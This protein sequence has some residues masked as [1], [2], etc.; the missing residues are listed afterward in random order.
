MNKKILSQQTLVDYLNT[1]LD[2]EKFID[3]D[4]S[5]NGLQIYG[6]KNNIKNIICSVDLSVELI[7]EAIKL[8][9]DM[10]IV[11][12]GIS[13]DGGIKYIDENNYKKISKLI[14]NNIS[15]YAIHLPLD[16][17]RKLGNNISI[18][19][20]IVTSSYI[21][22]IDNISSNI[23]N[24]KTLKDIGVISTIRPTHIDVLSKQ[25]DNNLNK[26]IEENSYKTI[27]ITQ[28]QKNNISIYDNSNSKKINRIYIISGIINRDIVESI[29]T[30]KIDCIITGEFKHDLFFLVREN[31]IS[32]IEAGHY[33]TEFTGIVSLARHIKDNFIINVLVINI[34]TYK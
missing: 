27:H 34:P 23:N 10:I 16:A 22:Q 3:I 17:N 5:N 4:K 30:E 1:L 8:N 18:A 31:N 12:H 20:N 24:Q 33:R 15:L 9:A 13:H 28:Q 25:V 11:H 7:D 26:M 32:V 21:K 6:N 19:N 29:L 14:Q 2:I